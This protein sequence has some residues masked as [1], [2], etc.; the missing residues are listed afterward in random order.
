MKM[1]AQRNIFEKIRNW[2][3][4][5]AA[6]ADSVAVFHYGVSGPNPPASSV[7]AGAL[8]GVQT[9]PASP[10]NFVSRTGHYS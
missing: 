2:A 7:T 6:T 10:A 1:P 4:P 8:A 5:L 3:S 9:C